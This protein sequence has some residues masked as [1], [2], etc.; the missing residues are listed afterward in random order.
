M[1]IPKSDKAERVEENCAAANLVLTM[2]QIEAV[3]RIAV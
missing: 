3:N 2:D 1:V